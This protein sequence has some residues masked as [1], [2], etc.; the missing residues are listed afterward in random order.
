MSQTADIINLYVQVNGNDA[1]NKLTDMRKRAAELN[2]EM[3]GLKK[4]SAEYIEKN[5]ELDTVKTKMAALQKQIGITGLTLKELRQEQTRLQSLFSSA[6]PF[7]KQ[8]TDLE[9]SLV[10]VKARIYDVTNGVQGFA[11]IWSRINDQVKQFGM[12]A[13]GYLGFQFLS[14][15]FTSI[16]MGAGKLSDQLADLQRVTG[17]TKDEANSLNKSLKEIDTRTSTGGLREISII[18]GKLG[19]AKDDIF[20]FTKA[21]DELVVSLGDELGDADQITSQLGKILNVFDG[22]ITGDNI[23]KL[24]NAIVELANTGAAT[25]GFITEF[26]QRLSGIAKSAGLSLGALSGLGAGLEEMGSRVESSSTAIQKLIIHINQDMPGA[27]KVAGMSLDD[28]QGLFKSDATEAILRYSEGL[29]KNKS[30]FEEMTASLKD[31]GE[32][33]ARTI[34]TIAKLGTGADVLRGRIELGKKSIEETGAITVAFNLK[35][36]TLGAEL[37]K[38]GKEF[39]RLVTSSAVT[40]FL[41]SAVEG[42]INLIKWL[43]DLP[44]FLKENRTAM[45]ALMTVIVAYT[46]AKTKL[47]LATIQNKLATILET[48]AD[49]IQAAQTAISTTYTKAYTFAK[50]VL[51]GKIK[52]ATAA[53]QIWNTVIKENPLVWLAALVLA[54]AT[55]ISAF[56]KNI[57]KN[58]EVQQN[59][60]EILAEINKQNSATK[61][62]IEEMTA[63]MNS[64]TAGVE[65][66]ELALQRLK[67][68]SNGYLDGLN[69]ENFATKEGTALLQQYVSWLDKSAEAKA[70]AALKSKL[71]E[72]SLE[73]N[74]KLLALEVEKQK[75]PEISGWDKFMRGKDNK[76]FGMGDRNSYDV[77]E[78][79]KKEAENKK[80]IN[81]QLSSLNNENNKIIEN[82]RT[83]ISKETATLKTLQSGSAEA[84]SLSKKI[85]E[86]QKL[87]FIYTGIGDTPAP[88]VSTPFTPKSEPNKKLADEAAQFAKEMEKLQRDILL[89]GKNLDDSEVAAI[90]AKYA[91]L[92]EKAKKYSFSL[93]KLKGMENQE[94]QQLYDKR[95]KIAQQ[96]SFD[97]EYSNAI[98]EIGKVYDELR[99]LAG[100]DYANKIIDKKTYTAKLEALDLQEKESLKHTAGDYADTVKKAADDLVKYTSD[101][102]HANTAAAIKGMEERTALTNEEA[103][104]KAKLDVIHARDGSSQ[105]LQAQ[106][107]LLQLQFDQDT[108]FM[109]K[110]SQMYLLKE[111]ELQKQLQDIDQNSFA[112]RLQRVLEF[113]NSYM[114]AF[115]SLA[116]ILG[117][118][119]ARSV[120]KDKAAND[121]KAAQYKQQ[122]D[123]KFISQAQYD[124]KM[125]ALQDANDQRQKEADIATAKREKALAEFQAFINTALAVTKYL[126]LGQWGKAILAGIMGGLE[127]AAIASKDLPQLGLGDWVRDGNTHANGG[128]N[129]NI[130]RNEAVIRAAAMTDPNIY[131]VTGTTAQ[132]TSKLNSLNGGISWAPG[133]TLLPRWRTDKPAQI[134]STLPGIL[135]ANNSSASS[136]TIDFTGMEGLLKAQIKRQDDIVEELKNMKTK[137][138]AVVS[139]KEFR[140]EEKKYD[141]A[142]KASSLKQS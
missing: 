110:K 62:G 34:E 47:T 42:T 116:Q 97:E 23:S 40:N 27:A 24:G 83:N 122:L 15:Q 71:L 52:L 114:Q 113:I 63:V 48:A 102:E 32:E 69:M 3:K 108:A 11:S 65:E 67:S 118:R 37:D 36:Q 111:A 59:H 128:V 119:D 88:G 26:D 16:I 31:A 72:Q 12:L 132:I 121:A 135:A 61:Q 91:D 84:K 136:S 41:K 9:K 49:K 44:A 64:S 89:K 87:L 134:R 98:I 46:A 10:A 140:K 142:K 78:D 124:I 19:V 129:R 130:E 141:A 105:K 54:V 90:Q 112:T 82:L 127:I 7:S 4:T 35:N 133:A 38:L 85:T 125:Q 79:I 123:G 57:L 60:A 139:I 70:R 21:M 74:N 51:T 14:S 99:N 28:F 68:I 13:A 20:E 29:V 45:L 2:V 106:K 115:E 30:S 73:S 117:N 25:G 80:M 5:K 131:S 39:N 101:A 6:V 93:I 55:A 1:Q 56:S 95:F 137:L 17:L 126:A 94:L 43:K 103:I 66:K 53:Q 92:F 120:Q 138:H 107:N 86:D 104:A 18:A 33:G 22:K 81:L 100:K 109:D 96:K 50:D 8:Y 76:F 58:T 75:Y 77:A